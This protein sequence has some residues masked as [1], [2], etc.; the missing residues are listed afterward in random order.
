[1]GGRNQERQQF[2]VVVAVGWVDRVTG[3]LVGVAG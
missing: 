2:V 3:N 1:M